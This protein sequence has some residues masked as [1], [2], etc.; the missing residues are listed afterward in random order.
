MKSTIQLFLGCC[1]FLLFAC[2]GQQAKETTATTAPATTETTA[3]ASVNNNG[4]IKTYTVNKGTVNWTGSKVIGGSSH[5]GTLSIALGDLRAKGDQIIGGQF[6]IDMNSINNTDLSADQGK[7]KLEGHLKSADFFDVAQYPTATFVITGS[8]PV[9]GQ[10]D[11]T[12]NI[13]GNLTIRD[14][15]NTVTF[16]ANV[17][18]VDNKLTAVTP[19]FTI[20]RTEYGVE[21]GSSSIVGLAKDKVISDDMA[22]VL[23]IEATSNSPVQ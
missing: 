12:H 19:S 10:A 18:V 13:T 21:Y 14:K 6:T 9:T 5:T 3:S 20:D 17:A 2:G 15:T 8:T 11:V 23:S 4:P 1:L 16:P 7:G 22:L